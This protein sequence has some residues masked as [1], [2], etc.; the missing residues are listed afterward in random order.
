MVCSEVF[1]WREGGEE[2]LLPVGERV[3]MEALR[4]L[5]S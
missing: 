4:C 1:G 3:L 2:D 5:D